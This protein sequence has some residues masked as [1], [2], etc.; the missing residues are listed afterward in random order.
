M[1]HYVFFPPPV[2]LFLRRVFNVL[3][4]LAVSNQYLATRR[5]VRRNG[6]AKGS[7]I[8]AGLVLSIQNPDIKAL[9][10]VGSTEK[11][12]AEPMG[13]LDAGTP[14]DAGSFILNGVYTYIMS[15]SGWYG[16][17]KADSH[18][19]AKSIEAFTVQGLPSHTENAHSLCK[20]CR[21]EPA[22]K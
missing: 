21:R 1:T 2:A 12:V 20:R 13:W 7:L 22:A 18:N 16:Q 14:I 10:G 9:A 4:T 8:A 17:P 3:S 5:E 15:C 11:L 19:L 6:D